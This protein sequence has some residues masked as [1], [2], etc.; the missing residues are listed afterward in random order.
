MLYLRRVSGDSM[1]PKLKNGQI[2]LAVKTVTPQIGDVIII[3]HNGLEK[4]KRLAKTKQ[5]E[6]YILGDNPER[7]T[8]SRTLGWLPK[9]IIKAR[10]I[11][12]RL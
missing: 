8:D 2:V 7:S 12:P 1:L 3:A 9:A 6:I 10:V 11:W 4:I 5:N